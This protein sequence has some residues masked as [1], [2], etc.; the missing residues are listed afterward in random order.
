MSSEEFEE[1]RGTLKIANAV[2]KADGVHVRIVSPFSPA[3]DAVP[4]EPSLE[5]AFLFYMNFYPD[6]SAGLRV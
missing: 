3:P 4:M 6:Q 2:R 5:D 1:A